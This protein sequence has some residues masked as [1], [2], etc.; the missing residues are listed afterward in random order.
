MSSTSLVDRSRGAPTTTRRLLVSWQ[1]PETRSII[2]VGVLT[3]GT[4]DGSDDYEF[5]Y[6]RRAQEQPDFRPFVGFPD[7]TTVYRSSRLFPFFENRVMSSSRPDFAAFLESI[8]L[9]D[10][11]T[12]FEILAHSEGRRVTDTVEIFPEP[13]IGPDGALVCRF[14]VRGVRHLPGAHDVIDTLRVGQ[15]L[16]VEAEPDNPTDPDA[17]LVLDDGRRI[18]WVPA[19]LTSLVHVPRQLVDD[20]AVEVVV[21]R[22]GDRAG[23]VHQRLLCR[24]TARW[25]SAMPMPFSGPDFEPAG[26]S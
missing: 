22:I 8:G 12:P 10:G 9:N 15:R 3:Q 11:A 19:F 1:D 20:G 23:P 5:T 16:V 25:P 14:H 26:R 7:L 18:G 17:V 2:P 4:P 6:L 24:L 13:V 21:E